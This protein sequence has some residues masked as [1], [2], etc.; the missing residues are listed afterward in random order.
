MKTAA[1]VD[2][3]AACSSPDKILRVVSERRCAVLQDLHAPGQ[4]CRENVE[5]VQRMTPRSLAVFAAAALFAS[6]PAGAD[7]LRTTVALA[8]LVIP[9]LRIEVAPRVSLVLSFPFVAHLADF[10][11]ARLALDLWIE[12]QYR[13]AGHE[14]RGLVGTRLTFGPLIHHET[15]ADDGI[16]AVFV[17]AAG[18]VGTDGDGMAIGGG[19]SAYTTR[20]ISGPS[21]GYRG[22]FVGGEMRHDVSLDLIRLRFRF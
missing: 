2:F 8:E 4:P 5:W 1:P 17:E 10:D 12:P 19:V 20:W 14:W 3:G 13:D 22:T 7:D 18:L 16:G 6:R 21:I 15:R 9:D 11:S